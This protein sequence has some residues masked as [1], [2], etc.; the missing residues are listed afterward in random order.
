MAKYKTDPKTAHLPLYK[1]DEAHVKSKALNQAE[2]SVGQI[3]QTTYH[4]VS[5]KFH[6]PHA[7]EYHNDHLKSIHYA[8]I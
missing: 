2:I 6:Q 1:Y 4:K 8:S 7:E 5:P 3:N